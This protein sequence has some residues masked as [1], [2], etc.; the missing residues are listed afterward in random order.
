[1]GHETKKQVKTRDIYKY[2]AQLNLDGSK[3]FRV[4][5]YNHNYASVASWESIRILLSTVLH[6]NCKKMQIDYVLDFPQAPAK[7]ECYMRIIKGIE[8]QINIE[9]LIKVD[10]NIYRKR[11][12]G[13]VCNKFLE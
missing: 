1:M 13:R 8:V 11:Q 3:F 10:N 7:R 9:W 4:V 2:K 6:N 5:D 12:A